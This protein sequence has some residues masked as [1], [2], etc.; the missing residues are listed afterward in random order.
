MSRVGT[1][2]LVLAALVFMASTVFHAMT[3]AQEGVT[4]AER[5]IA[6]AG[7]QRLTEQPQQMDLPGLFLQPGGPGMAGL[8]V[9]TMV[10]L[11]YHL[12]RCFVLPGPWRQARRN[13][14][15]AVQGP[16]ILGLV[17][18]AIWPWLLPGQPVVALV[19]AAAMLTAFLAA[20]MRG[21]RSGDEVLHSST[22]GFIAGWGMLI[23][24]AVLAG[25][26]RDE[27]GI[28]QEIA[29]VI[30]MLIGSVAA[31]SVQLRL[32][33]RTGFSLALLWGLICLAGATVTTDAVIATM[34]V[35][36]IAIIAVAMVRVLT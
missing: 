29:A 2:L 16:L 3:P 14:G 22:L 9:V 28:P 12:A 10:A 27:L 24:F 33:R 30:T 8:M 19:L 32:G 31:V 17:L 11:V 7:L 23:S 18:G 26:L 13:D 25:L 4:L 1:L 35:I 5:G 36:S 20:A 6:L 34:A 21:V 15:G